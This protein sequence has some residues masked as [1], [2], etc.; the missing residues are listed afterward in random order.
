MKEAEVEYEIE[1]NANK[2]LI[3][4]TSEEESIDI[5]ETE[6]PQPVS[7]ENT[8]EENQNNRPAF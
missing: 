8:T 2:E 7:E 1:N 6:N 3:D 5:E 4:V